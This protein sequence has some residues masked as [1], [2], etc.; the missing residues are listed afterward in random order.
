MTRFLGHE[1]TT[2][3]LAC[4][5]V[6]SAF[7]FFAHDSTQDK[8]LLERERTSIAF[9]SQLKKSLCAA[10]RFQQNGKYNSMCSGSRL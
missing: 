9:A 7:A 3:E 1:A 10:A 4:T 2:D 5:R 8:T 6:T